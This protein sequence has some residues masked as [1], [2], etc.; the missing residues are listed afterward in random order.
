MHHT[1]ASGEALGARS[2]SRVS[3]GGPVQ[4]QQQQGKIVQRFQSTAFAA[5]VLPG[6][7]RVDVGRD[8]LGCLLESPE[9][10]SSRGSAS[11]IAAFE[12]TRLDS[13]S[14]AVP[15]SHHSQ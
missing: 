11:D 3:R 10:A 6:P 2:D 14:G 12:V 1:K 5:A 13:I 4:Q 15:I 9:I 8:G 7:T